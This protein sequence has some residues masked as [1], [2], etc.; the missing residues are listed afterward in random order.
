[1]DLY[2]NFVYLFWLLLRSFLVIL[3]SVCFI[4][5]IVALIRVRIIHG[6]IN[7]AAAATVKQRPL[8]LRL[9]WDLP[10]QIFLDYW[11]KS[12]LGFPLHGLWLVV[13]EQGSGKTTTMSYII[14]RLC[15]RYPLVKLYTNYTDYYPGVLNDPY[16][17]N[18]LL[19]CDRTGTIFA[20]DE[21]QNW[22]S[23]SDS[24]DFDPEFLAFF[25]QLRKSFCVTIGT[26]QVF[27]RVS[28]PLREQVRY[29]F[30][31]RT[32][33]GCF[34]ICDVYE[35]TILS[36][37][38]GTVDNLRRIKRFCFVQT[39][40]LRSTFDTRR[41]IAHQSVKRDDQQPK[42]YIKRRRS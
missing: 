30:A 4:C 22:F 29:V 24:K 12:E 23:C 18:Y 32:F 40:D 38:D 16:G 36:S 31:P 11:H 34:T 19:T 26:S 39:D 15:K 28:K 42:P 7:H 2:S 17:L 35:P 33:F 6:K 27:S 5:L 14:D 41:K 21:L 3:L 8:I 37:G 10:Y 25:T 1:M 20:I 13:G 9:L